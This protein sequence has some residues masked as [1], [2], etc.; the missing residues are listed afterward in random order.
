[1]LTPE[2]L[3]CERWGSEGCQEA[4][5]ALVAQGGFAVVQNENS[6]VGEGGT[7][8]A[9][10]LDPPYPEGWLLEGSRMKRG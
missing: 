8:S 1:M 5:Q 10:G 6:G 4:L 9:L 2:M 7:C 3:P